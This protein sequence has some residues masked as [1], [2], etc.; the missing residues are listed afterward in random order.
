MKEKF[1]KYHVT[2]V[3]RNGERFKIVT[4]CEMHAAGINLWQGTKWGVRADG[5]R[6]KLQEV[7]N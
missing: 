3:T 5:T 4:A 6:K 7:Y 1:V 2:G